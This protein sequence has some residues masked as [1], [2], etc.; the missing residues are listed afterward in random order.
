MFHIKSI[1]ELY[2]KFQVNVSHQVYECFPSDLKFKS[3][4]RINQN[5]RKIIEMRYDLPWVMARGGHGLPKVLPGPT[6]PY[7]LAMPCEQSPVKQIYGKATSGVAAH[8]TGYLQ[9]SSTPLNTPH[10]TLL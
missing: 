1:K 2:I 9:P 8:R 5:V 7:P 3:V 6:M 4:S 10:R